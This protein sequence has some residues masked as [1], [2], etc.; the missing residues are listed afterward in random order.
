MF[1]EQPAHR[2]RS[3]ADPLPDSPSMLA[4]GLGRSYGDSCLNE[5]GLLLATRGL[6]RFLA[7]DEATGLL[8]CEAGTSLGEILDLMVPRGW[9]P[10]V[11]PGTKHVTVGGA[12]ANDIHGKNHHVAGTFGS[13]VVRLGLKRS[14]GDTECGPGDEMFAATLG[15]LGLTGLITWADIQMRRVPGAGIEEE[16]VPMADLD[17][18]VR[19]SA[20]SGYEYT[21]AW[22]DSLARGSRIGRGLFIRGNHTGKSAPRAPAESLRVPFDAPGFALNAL[23]VGAFNATY[24][25]ARLLRRRRTLHY[26]PFFFPLDGVAD[27]NRLYGRRGFH[28]HQSVVADIE[29]VRN[30]L[31]A[32]AKSR[33][34][35]FLTVLKTFGDKPSPGRLSFPRKGIT[36]A[37]DFPHRGA[38]TLE[39]LDRLDRLVL[40]AGGRTYPAKDARMSASTFQTGYPEWKELEK[41]RDPKF[42]SGFWRRVT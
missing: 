2:L 28:Q 15:G 3:T 40:D 30:L 13:H 11:L 1:P 17:D 34:P 6:D 12:I 36:L 23:T 10:P 32:S 24:R 9:F 42:A 16:V 5:G 19:L 26:A 14:D 27:W 7:F 25:R 18:F 29:A 35:S 37:L 33:Q 31:D 41:Y 39:L 22:V 20:E 38:K 4:H 21:V 8:R